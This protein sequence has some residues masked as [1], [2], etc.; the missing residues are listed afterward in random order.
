M[1]ARYQNTP[2]KWENWKDLREE[3]QDRIDKPKRH[4]TFVMYFIFVLILGGGLGVWLPP[5]VT[6]LG[7]QRPGSDPWLSVAVNLAT[8]LIAILSSGL[9]DTLLSEVSRAVRMVA[10]SLS[11][12]GVVLAV[13]VFFTP[14]VSSAFLLSIPGA[15]LSLLLWWLANAHDDKLREKEVAVNA[16]VGNEVTKVTLPGTVANYET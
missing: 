15:M 16:P 12:I 1:S 10:F 4:P 3:I 9:A 5:L 6:A 11:I 7:G 2:S 14:Y 8:Y 13:L